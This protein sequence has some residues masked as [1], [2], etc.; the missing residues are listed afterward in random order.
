MATANGRL[1]GPPGPSQAEDGRRLP[2]RSRAHDQGGR[3]LRLRPTAGAR[4][5]HSQEIAALRA[6]RQHLEDPSLDA[7]EAAVGAVQHLHDVISVEPLPLALVPRQGKDHSRPLQHL[8]DPLGSR[9]DRAAHF[10]RQCLANVTGQ[11]GARQRPLYVIDADIIGVHESAHGLE[12]PTTRPAVP[13]PE[14]HLSSACRDT[15][16]PRP[17]AGRPDHEA[18]GAPAPLRR[19]LAA[20]RKPARGPESTAFRLS[21]FRRLRQSAGDRKRPPLVMGQPQLRVMPLSGR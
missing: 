10:V 18:D 3:R 6:R 7:I 8:L 1:A 5:F 15:T 4:A 2:G 14:H 21:V 20:A 9:L 11:T 12:P 16:R 13:G 19:R 17:R